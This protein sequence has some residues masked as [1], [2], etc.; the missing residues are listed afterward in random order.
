MIFCALAVAADMAAGETTAEEK[1]K[2]RRT[3][4]AMVAVFLGFL[5]E[6]IVMVDVWNEGQVRVL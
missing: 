4:D 5:V 3:R 1:P 2:R 6:R